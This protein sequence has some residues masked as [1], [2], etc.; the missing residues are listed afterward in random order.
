MLGSL[1]DW[2]EWRLPTIKPNPVL[3]LGC[4]DA[5]QELLTIILGWLK[6][7]VKEYLEE[8]H[9]IVSYFFFQRMEWCTF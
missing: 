2:A 8:T 6:V 3:L 7:G 9:E 1:S 5:G 4:E